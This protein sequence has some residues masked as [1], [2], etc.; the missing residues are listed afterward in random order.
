MGLGSDDVGTSRS[1]QAGKAGK[2]SL[3]KATAFSASVG[4]ERERLQIYQ[5]QRGYSR[6][7]HHLVYK[8]LSAKDTV[9]VT[10]QKTG[11]RFQS[12]AAD[13]MFSGE[14]GDK[15]HDRIA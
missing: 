15:T 2:R 1:E 12:K 5:S 3:G 13:R 11:P 14:L 9:V 6:H 10:Y 8:S 4:Q 7:S